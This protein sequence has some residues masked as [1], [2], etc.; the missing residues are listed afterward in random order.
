MPTPGL[1]LLGFMEQPA[2]AAYLSQV[3]VPPPDVN[4]H[5]SW[6]EARR[7][8]GAPTKNSGRP[9]IMPFPKEHFEYV[10]KLKS[11]PRFLNSL[12]G[13]IWDFKLVELDPV[14]AFQFHVFTERTDD[15]CAALSHPPT[16]GELLS[17]CLP[18]D[19]EQPATG[20]S[21]Q[22][23]SLSLW[24]HSMNFR[25]HHFGQVGLDPG[26]KFA[27]FGI[28]V[29]PAFPLMQV[30]QFEGRCFLRNGY[31][32]AY[33]LKKKGVTHVPCLF[34]ETDDYAKIGA[35]GGN[36]TFERALLESADPP[37]C[38][39]LTDERAYPVML[40]NL[41]RVVQLTWSDYVLPEA[42]S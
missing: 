19:L 38:A 24:S 28:V 25:V 15:L 35:P 23:N 21:M 40:K 10:E 41:T 3:C 7:A 26:Q 37:T 1:S 17:V 2:A 31:H 4:P 42:S 5:E 29:G 32:R 27:A 12:E 22:P 36:A 18:L 34:F 6:V 33:G 14:L 8:L 30:I 9:A 20:M 11:H 13:M 16:M 39:H